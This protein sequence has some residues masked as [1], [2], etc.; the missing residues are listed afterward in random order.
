MI[1]NVVLVSGVQQSDSV[2]HIRVSILFQILFP[3][4]LLQ[5]IEQSSLCYTV[6]PCLL[7]V[8]NI[9]VCTC[10][11]TLYMLSSLIHTPFPHSRLVRNLTINSKF[12]LTLTPSVRPLLDFPRGFILFFLLASLYFDP[13]FTTGD[14]T[15]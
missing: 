5:N 3:F 14:R 6:G 9:A 13:T 10:Y 8:L 15:V 4:R 11:T 12:S 1:D 2:T 7:S